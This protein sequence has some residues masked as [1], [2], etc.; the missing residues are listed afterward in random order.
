M[1]VDRNDHLQAQISACLPVGTLCMSGT[2]R[3]TISRSHASSAI[4]GRHTAGSPGTRGIREVALIAILPLPSRFL[5]SLSLSLL[6][7]TV[8][9]PVWNSIVYTR[10]YTVRAGAPATLPAPESASVR[11][12]CRPRHVG[13][14]RDD[15]PGQR[16]PWP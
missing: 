5:F 1:R 15:R 3:R 4:P 13:C 10:V 9:T 12:S 7:C 2:I 11:A 16:S 6:Y 8:Y 14:G